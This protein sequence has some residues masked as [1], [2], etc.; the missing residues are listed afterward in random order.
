MIE[1][2]G[3][4]SMWAWSICTSM[5]PLVLHVWVKKPRK[6]MLRHIP[7]F[8]PYYT[9][10]PPDRH[11]IL[12]SLSLNS[13]WH[14]LPNLVVQKIFKVSQVRLPKINIKPNQFHFSMKLTNQ[15]CQNTKKK[16]K[17][18]QGFRTNHNF[19]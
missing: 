6:A 1:P 15:N 13:H 8:T 3:R 16:K 7:Y 12:D 5:S 10:V 11:L 19:I 14:N 18:M 2:E 4:R 9:L 17:K